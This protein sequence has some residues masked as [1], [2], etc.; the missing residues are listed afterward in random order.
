[1]LDLGWTELLL[2]GIVALIVVGPKDLPVMFRSL[3]RFTGRMR[4]MA[5]EFTRAMDEAADQSGARD[6]ARDL[7]TMSNPRSAATKGF[8][9]ATGLDEFDDLADDI[10]DEGAKDTSWMDTGKKK[11]E[12]KASAEDVRQPTRG[13][14]TEALAEKRA[15]ESAARKAEAEERVAQRS[16]AAQ[17]SPA[18]APGESAPGSEAQRASDTKHASEAQRASEPE[19]VAEPQSAG[20][21]DS[22]PKRDRA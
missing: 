8:K 15:A 10:E 6:I 14:N 18:P 17:S 19:R 22:T 21:A 1:M 2:I 5:R 12:P 20:A 13:P 4:N 11:A 7:R 3:G 9:K 16:A